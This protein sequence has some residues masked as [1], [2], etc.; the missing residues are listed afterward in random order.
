MNLYLEAVL[1]PDDVTGIYNA[2]RENGY[3][4]A[5]SESYVEPNKYLI[6]ERYEKGFSGLKIF[7]IMICQTS[8]GYITD[9][10]IQNGHGSRA[11]AECFNENEIELVN[12]T[13]KEFKHYDRGTN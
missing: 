8:T 7:K 5:D 10:T 2:W 4:L 9:K 11:I 3:T 6:F 1:Q 12:R 13:I